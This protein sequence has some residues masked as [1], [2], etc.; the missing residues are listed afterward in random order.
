MV[1]VSLFRHIRRHRPPFSENGA[2]DEANDR[3]HRTDH[4]RRRHAGFDTAVEMVAGYPTL[5]A[6]HDH[7]DEPA[8]PSEATELNIIKPL[9]RCLGK[10]TPI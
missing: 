4:E 1:S 7:A 2:G 5:G 3:A 8:L 10:Y 6:R 9:G